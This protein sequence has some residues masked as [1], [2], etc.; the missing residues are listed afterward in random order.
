MDAFICSSLICN[1]NV[2]YYMKRGGSLGEVC[3]APR[4]LVRFLVRPST[5]AD[6]RPPAAPAAPAVRCTP[7]APTAPPVRRGCPTYPRSPPCPFAR[8][9]RPSAC[10]PCPCTRPCVRPLR[11][12]FC[13]TCPPISL[14]NRPPRPTVC[15]DRPSLTPPGALSSWDC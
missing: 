6:C 15:L 3:R 12:P 13:L 9:P 4:P 10:S 14:Q 5:P 7:Y 8:S 2:K 1:S 11:S